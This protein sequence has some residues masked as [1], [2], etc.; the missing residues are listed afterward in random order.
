MA[1]GDKLISLSALNIVTHPHSPEQYIELFR[2]LE[3]NKS[4]TKMYGQHHGILSK[5]DIN[6]NQGYILGKLYRFT[7]INQARPWI[8]TIEA[9]QMVDQ[10][11]KPIQ[12]VESNF[13]PNSRE[14]WF[15]FIIKHHRL[16]F[17]SRYV[18]PISMKNFFENIISST[19]FSKISKENVS[20]SIEQ[21][22][23]S[24]D[25]LLKMEFIKNITFL[26]NKPNPDELESIEN[27]LK[28]RLENLNADRMTESIESKNSINPD[29][30]LKSM[31]KVARS[32]G[33]VTIKGRHEGKLIKESTEAHP[34]KEPKTYNE[35]ETTYISAL[36]AH[37]AV[38]VKEIMDKMKS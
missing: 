12:L 20:I 4:T 6:E 37:A 30:R 26:I 13:K 35:N 31:M 33:Y 18:A 21:S 10:D 14:I 19:N 29:N 28:D 7:E 32:N 9:Q 8:D 16:V 27:E 24:L 23:E 22:E 5:I 1:K 11:G 25:E 2:E 36:V 15:V 3:P 38:F 17:D 34:I